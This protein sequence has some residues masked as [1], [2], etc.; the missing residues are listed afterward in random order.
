MCFDYYKDECF[1][2]D[3]VTKEIIYAPD[4]LLEDETECVMI[5]FIRNL[6]GIGSVPFSN[7]E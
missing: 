5:N 3:S 1:V 6:V 4:Y 2:Y 7:I